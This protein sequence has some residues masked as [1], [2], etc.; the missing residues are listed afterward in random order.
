MTI[1]V[2]GPDGR[3]VEFPDGTPRHVMER[4]LAEHYGTSPASRQAHL[5]AAS[6]LS[7]KRTAGERLGEVFSNTWQESWI[8]EGWREGYLR[9]SRG[10]T[11]AANRNRG[12][13]D[14]NPVADIAEMVAGSRRVM[15]GFGSQVGAGAEADAMADIERERTRRA[16]FRAT[17]SEDPF[18]EAGDSFADRALHG[19]A[20]LVGTLGATALDPLSYVTGGSTALARVGVQAGVA[21]GVDVLAQTSA[22]NSGVEDNYDLNR[23]LLSGA[24][25]G[26]FVGA[27]EGAGAGV[28]AIQNSRGALRA[29]REAQLRT[30]TDTAQT[31]RDELDTVDAM[32]Q[33]ALSRNDWTQSQR[34]QPDP[35]ATNLPTIERADE[36]GGGQ[37][38]DQNQSSEQARPD[39]ND[40]SNDP[41]NG[42]DWGV[43]GS[44]E[45]TRAALAHLDSLKQFIKPDRVEQFV[46]W[47]GKE[48]FDLGP[49]NSHWNKDFFD[50]DKLM[51]DPDKFQELSDVMSSIFRPLYDAAGDAT[52][53]WNSVKQRQTMFGLTM[54]D[55]IKA[56][57]D[58]TGDGGV[59]AK[60]HAI[61]TIAAQQTDRLAVK[62][63]EFEVALKGGKADASQIA[64]VAA[65]LQA[66]VMMDAMAAGS[67]SEV[68]RALNI[69]KAQKKRT[70]VL[71]DIQAQWDAMSDAMN[72][73]TDAESMAKAAGRMREAYNRRGANGLR[74]ELRKVRKMGFADYVSYYIVSGYLSTP[75]TAM[76]NVAGS[77]FH[78]V[79]N[80]GER[81]VAAGITS[82]LRRTL[83]GHTSRE[84][85][86][87]REAN[88]Y[89]AGV[90]QSFIEAAR[91]SARAFKEARPQSDME[92]RI[93]YVAPQIPFEV[94]SARLAKWRKGG[95]KSVPD[96][97][98]TS[99]FASLRTLGVR[100]T[101]AM[102]EFTK[103]MGR[104]MQLNAL[105]SREASYRSARMR[106][107]D[108]ERVYR[109]TYTNIFTEPTAEALEQ[110]RTAFRD[111]GFGDADISGQARTVQSDERL[112]QAAQIIMGVDLQAAAADHARMLAF[113][114]GG[115]KVQAAEKFLKMFPVLKAFYVPFLRTPLALVRAGLVDRNPAM[116]W[117]AKENRD[118]FGNYFL[119]AKT[120][121]EQLGRGGAEADLAMARMVT[122]M[123]L[124]G[125]AA[126][127]YANGDITGSRKPSEQQDGVRPYSVRIGGRWY[128]YAQFSPLAEMI[129]LTVD[130]LEVLNKHDHSPE[131]GAAIAGGMLAAV[132]QNIFN[133]AALQGV[134][135]F[136]EMI[137]PP[138][139]SDDAST[140]E[141]VGRAVAKKLG[142]SFTPAIVRNL[143]WD[144]DP[145]IR[146]ARGFLEAFAANIPLWSE[147]LPE[148][149]DWLGLPMVRQDG[150]TGLFQFPRN[151]VMT[152][153]IVKLEVSALAQINPE[154]Q[155]ARRPPAR[156]NNEKIEPNEQARLLQI[157]GQEFRDASGRNMHESLRE[158]IE[159]D[160]YLSW[161]DP[162][163]ADAI[164]TMVSRY[165]RGA[166]RAIRAG[167]YRDDPIIREM[168][169]RTGME[170]AEDFG[171]R[172]G[173]QDHQVQ[174]RARRYGVTANQL[175]E[176]LNFEPS[177]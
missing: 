76:L 8:A 3:I 18:W 61:E 83:L 161:A 66:T 89:V 134:A 7:P 80:I 114:T 167:R 54:S 144:S 65:E 140:G 62:L 108:A 142:D 71:N 106:G 46:R 19:G 57:A 127:L 151:S 5:N 92:T 93:G 34:A 82:P 39:A 17:S 98:A 33:P 152:D 163:R 48:Q 159:S 58:I 52:R 158:L 145:T 40:P 30:E 110:S 109:Q 29:Q 149:R 126:M 25:G 51:A 26:A 105:A 101:L 21:A 154:I 122:G 116:A 130:T 37:R 157:Q 153:D 78:A 36:P 4:A 121:D 74:D 165:R 104:R 11:H 120:L 111:A 68:A 99:V 13:F 63:G 160:A 174:N 97:A 50:F 162:Q 44:P 77:V 28:R 67:K 94:N 128:A 27:I 16:E 141:R 31:I 10:P 100:P 176:V 81:Y 23:T 125:T 49:G 137:Y 139:A 146:E 60:I 129:G 148:R 35:E 86:T 90:H 123:G 171:E 45:R 14:L 53:T 155:L 124:I 73:A 133:K 6:A 173:L 15:E 119:A 113:Q 131:Q 43:V 95:I 47:L 69:M 177:L 117:M 9:G 70:A 87:F 20:A 118:A 147:T 32:T 112:E 172:R 12:F 24:A 102:D 79:A 64:D 166:N 75:T 91:M 156:F 56:H 96:M 107:K 175:D 169:A 84:A 103:V 55:V 136:F 22:V 168:V 150:Q 72:G 38:Q 164:T 143:A 85:V 41:W 2:T 170:Q 135:D 42:V 138:F 115:P 1:R 59:S 88:A 132:Q